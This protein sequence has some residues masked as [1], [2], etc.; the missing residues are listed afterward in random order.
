[1]KI[2]AL[3]ALA[4]LVATSAMAD[5]LSLAYRG[6]GNRAGGYA[7]LLNRGGKIS[8]VARQAR[9]P[10]SEI[11]LAYRGTGN[12][13]EGM[14]TFSTRAAKAA[15][16]FSAPTNQ[17]PKSRSPTA[18]TAI[19]QGDR[20]TFSIQIQGPSEP[21]DQAVMDHLP[22]SAVPPRIKQAPPL[23]WNGQATVARCAPQ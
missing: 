12:R 11:P 7:Y 20:P 4:T 1:M 9:D 18:G 22:E 17:G 23:W 19:V 13:A 16:R 8:G 6:N 10:K 2:F 3:T 15:G 21:L 14:P 5:D